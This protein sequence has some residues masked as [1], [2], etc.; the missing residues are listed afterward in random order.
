MSTLFPRGGLKTED[1][2][3]KDGKKDPKDR[4]KRKDRDADLLATRKPAKRE[5]K[6]PATDS[7]TTEQQQSTPLDVLTTTTIVKAGRGKPAKLRPVR[8]ASYHA[9]TTVLGVVRSASAKHALVSLPGNLV[10]HVDVSGALNLTPNTIVRCAVLSTSRAGAA[11]GARKGPKR[12]ELS[13]DAR[14]V[15]KGLRVEDLVSKRVTTLCGLIASK[16]A[17]GYVVDVGIGGCTGFLAF[18]NCVSE[19]DVGAP[20]ECRVLNLDPDSGVCALTTRDVALATNAPEK[21]GWSFRALCVGQRV[22]VCVHRRVATGLVVMFADGALA[23]VIERDHT[24]AGALVDDDA[25]IADE[26]FAVGQFL[27]AR[28]LLIDRAAKVA[29][30]TCA[31]HLLALEGAQLPQPGTFLR[32]CSVVRRDPKV[33]LVLHKDGR[34]VFVHKSR[35]PDDIESSLVDVRVVGVAPL[36]GWALASMSPSALDENVPVAKAELEPGTAVQATVVMTQA[37]GLEVRLSETLTGQVTNLHVTESGGAC[38]PRK[39]RTVGDAVACRVLRVEARRIE[40]TCKKSLVEATR[41]LSSY[42]DASANCGRSFSGFV[43][44]ADAA[45]GLVVTFF[46]NV[47]GRVDPH[48]LK[49]RGIADPAQSFA[50]GTVVT[51]CVKGVTTPRPRADG[52]PRKPRIALTLD[53]VDGCEVEVHSVLRAVA[54]ELVE[55]R[56]KGASKRAP[57]KAVACLC[58]VT[59]DKGEC[60]AKLPVAHASDHGRFAEATLRRL[61]SSGNPFECCVIEAASNGHPAKITASPSMVRA[62]KGALEVDA[63][64]VGCITQLKPYGAFVSFGGDARGLIPR[65]LIADRFVGDLEECFSVGD[66]VR[67][68]VDSKE[69]DRVVLRTRGVARDETGAF[70][71]SVLAALAETVATKS[72]TLRVGHSYDALV[73]ASEDGVHFSK[74]NGLEVRGFAPRKHSLTCA[75][76][77]VVK[78]RLL[79]FAGDV[80]LCSMAP[81]VVRPG[82]TKRRAKALQAL[83]VGSTI[84]H[85]DL[86]DKAF[87]Q[88]TV[89]GC[90]VHVDRATGQLIS[91]QRGDFHRRDVDGTP[92]VEEDLVVV[93]TAQDALYGLVIAMP[94]EDP[95]GAEQVRHRRG[96]VATDAAAEVARKRKLPKTDLSALDPGDALTCRVAAR[97]SSREALLLTIRGG[98]GRVRCRLHVSDAATNVLPMCRAP[99]AATE[100]AVDNLP[101]THPFFGVRCGSAFDGVLLQRTIEG[102]VTRVDVGVGAAHDTRPAEWGAGVTACT[103]LSA[104]DEHGYVTAAAAPGVRA[105]VAFADVVETFLDRDLAASVAGAHGACAASAR[106]RVAPTKGGATCRLAA[107][108]AVRTLARGDVVPCVPSSA[109]KEK[110]R[111]AAR[112]GALDRRYVLPTGLEAFCAAS[113]CT[114]RD[115]WTDA[116]SDAG[117]ALCVVLEAGPPARISLRQS[118]VEQA[119]SGDRRAVAPDEALALG[120][121]RPGFVVGADAKA[122]VFVE[123]AR[124]VIGRV[125]LKDLADGYVKD[126]VREFPIGRLVAPVVT[127]V[128]PRVE[129]SLRPSAIKRE[130]TI[131]KSIAAGDVVKG[132]VTRVEAYGVFVRLDD[133]PA[134]ACSGL[135]HKSELADDFVKDV[136]TRFA[137]GDRVV[138]KVLKLEQLDTRRKVS[139]GLKPSYFTTEE[140]SDDESA[141]DQALARADAL[142]AGDS[143]SDEED[144]LVEEEAAEA[145]DESDASDEEEDASDDDNDA[146]VDAA[147]RWD[148]E[149][150]KQ[151]KRRKTEPADEGQAELVAGAFEEALLNDEMRTADDYERH[152]VAHQDESEAYTT[153]ATFLLDRED[154]AQGARRVLE[155]GLKTIH[156]RIEDERL[157]VWACLLELERAH[158]DGKALDATTKRAVANCDPTKVLLRLGALLDRAEDYAKAD[159][160]YRKCEKRSKNQSKTPEDVWLA[161]A[162][163]RLLSGD[164]P[165]ADAVVKRGVQ[166]CAGNAKEEAS[167]LGRFACLEL[168]VGS[169]A[170]GRT[171]FDTLLER[172]PRR[173]DLWQLYIAKTLKAG[174]VPHTRAVQARLAAADLPPKTMNAALKRF[175]AFEAEHG[176]A[177]TAAAVKDLARAYVARRKGAMDD[178]DD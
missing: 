84:A 43:T 69:G 61:A 73:Q 133:A 159:A 127:R 137:K 25:F 158:G 18:K 129:L 14:G 163:S 90:A 62:A 100:L 80:A 23:G 130:G 147:L 38:D 135:A 155:R 19:I 37:W 29:R 112:C 49:S 154:D 20:V 22:R 65:A 55:A 101:A 70:C 152:L 34:G 53:D 64:R 138:A 27:D 82:R 66:V 30:L 28:V 76:G 123:L 153:Y 63:V 173:A 95:R 121:V 75:A 32:N 16:E 93:S 126:V 8:F 99:A 58:R 67:C 41:V 131:A 71:R 150:P 102:Q 168:D 92:A 79:A 72:R 157:A 52:T 116:S 86:L 46:G 144:D 77:D 10:G 50:L 42:A 21:A 88:P 59:T 44:G 170:R 106:L 111:G 35:L 143:S 39:H 33:G 54:V 171:V 31:A 175:A 68:S 149:Q 12:V 104:V 132:T 107:S 169:N 94:R 156:Y 141:D 98:E 87:V 118:R 125:L 36:E 165:G 166:A 15:Q 109:P 74:I 89:K 162:K 105:R 17:R 124:D 140:D 142:L 151:V 177:A 136:G 113:E 145:S 24:G 11:P 51:C 161:H 81:D 110:R 5:N 47:Q 148:E 83:G 4:K 2:Q 167:L 103:L 48:S 146:S 120:T 172:F 85:A 78:V 26:A 56:A 114:D 1:T 134:D 160:V 57:R 60:L 176:D 108:G 174:D 7:A 6:A 119:Q 122:G 96:S 97:G 9:E 115:A 91:V 139:L 3:K 178:E 128:A 164:A 13:I 45:R 40:L 117:V